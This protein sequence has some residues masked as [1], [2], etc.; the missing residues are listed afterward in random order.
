MVWYAEEIE[1][2]AS[3]PSLRSLPITTLACFSLAWGDLG[4][5]L[6]TK[7]YCCFQLIDMA[8]MR[9]VHVYSDCK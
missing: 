9:S 5:D 6:A 3:S 8:V 2:S 7:N 1:E 4:L